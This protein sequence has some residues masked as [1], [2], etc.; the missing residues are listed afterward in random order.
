MRW[1]LVLFWNLGCGFRQQ[2]LDDLKELETNPKEPPMVLLVST[3]T[4]EA[5]EAMGLSF[6]T[7]LDQE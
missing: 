3:G 4:K 7:L 6:P 5:N 1:L 2:M